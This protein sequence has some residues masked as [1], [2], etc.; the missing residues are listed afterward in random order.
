MAVERRIHGSLETPRATG[1]ALTGPWSPW[2]GAVALAAVGILTFLVLDRPWGITF[3]FGLW[4]ANI[5]E[6]LGFSREAGLLAPWGDWA[7]DNAVIFRDGTSVMDF[8]IIF[9]AMAA[10]SLA[11]RFAPVWRIPAKDIATAVAGG[12]LMGYGARLAYGCNIGGYLGGVVSGSLHG[13]VWAAAAFAG[14]SLVARLRMP[15]P[16]A[17]QPVRA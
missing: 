5:G 17:G 16:P 2:A 10:A 14:S 7:F 3:A 11:G 12:L 15:R 6:G 1:S 8:G 9:G 4:G 13:W